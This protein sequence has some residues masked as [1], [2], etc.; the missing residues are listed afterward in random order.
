[1]RVVIDMNTIIGHVLW[2]DSVPNRAVDQAFRE[3]K[4]LRSNNTLYAL[5]TLL[6]STRFDKYVTQEAR[7]KFLELYEQLTIPIEIQDKLRICEDPNHNIVLELAYNGKP[8][9]VI[10]SQRQLL[11][12]Q[13]FAEHVKIVTPA[14]FLTLSKAVRS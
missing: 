6:L 12:K 2:E 3:G 13:G 5:R 8:V 11:E 14:D 9:H 7:M 1:M 4:V 10:S